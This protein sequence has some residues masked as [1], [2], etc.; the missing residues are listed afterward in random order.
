MARSDRQ[1]D[2]DLYQVFP[3]WVRERGVRRL[4]DEG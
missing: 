3:A 2:R 1:E 4:L